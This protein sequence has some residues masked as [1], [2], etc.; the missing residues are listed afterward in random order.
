MA[1]D[2]NVIVTPGP[3]LACIF[4]VN[5]VEVDRWVASECH[6]NADALIQRAKEHAL[7]NF[8][9]FHEKARAGYEYSEAQCNG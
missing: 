3:D 6:G 5:G 4:S 9:E 2:I 8:I 7:Q 1:V